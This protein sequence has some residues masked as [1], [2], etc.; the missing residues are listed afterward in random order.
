M[1]D[2]HFAILDNY[3]H[4]L[5]V[6]YLVVERDGGNLIEDPDGFFDKFDKFDKH[7]YIE[8]EKHGM[9]GADK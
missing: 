6:L 2:V 5:N 9:N 3:S 7:A 1:F 8:H 4:D